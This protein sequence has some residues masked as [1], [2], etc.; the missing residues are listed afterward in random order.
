LEESHR[1]NGVPTEICGYDRNETVV[2]VRRPV[3]IKAILPLLNNDGP[4]FVG[5]DVADKIPQPNEELGC[6]SDQRITEN[7]PVSICARD[8]RS[9]VSVEPVAASIC[10]RRITFRTNVQIVTKVG[11]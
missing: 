11:A 3:A 2:P 6:L 5:L 4:V 10:N 1:V 7:S 8:P 9:T